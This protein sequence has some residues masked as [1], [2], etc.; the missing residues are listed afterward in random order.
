MLW[1]GIVGEPGTLKSPTLKEVVHPLEN[2][3]TAAHKVYAK[4]RET[5]LLE[6][7]VYQAT[8]DAM[9]KNLMKAAFKTDAST[10]IKLKQ[11]IEA[12]PKPKDHVFAALDVL[13]ESG[14]IKEMRDISHGK[15]VCTY[16][17][18]QHVQAKRF[19]S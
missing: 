19:V 14:W 7:D 15:T 16:I 10:L 6:M 1:G 4:K 8:K 3:A 18:N 11:Q 5:F 2:L 9:K 13:I 12:L 17:I